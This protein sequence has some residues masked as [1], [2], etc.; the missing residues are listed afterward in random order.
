MV[1]LKSSIGVVSA[2]LFCVVVIWSFEQKFSWVQITLGFITFIL[3][4]IFLSSIKG[5]VAIFL[6]LVLTV[7]AAYVCVK[8]EYFSVFIGIF[9]A[10]I[11]GF[12][13]HYYRVRK[14]KIN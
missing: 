12:P 14:T 3:P 5:N 9:L 2:L 4:I 10:F 7:L 8:F 1:R 13:I 11:L 6:A